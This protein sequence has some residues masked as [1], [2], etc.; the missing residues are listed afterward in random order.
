LK[1]GSNPIGLIYLGF[2]QQ[3]QFE[4]EQRNLVAAV[5]DIAGNALNRM[6]AT[7]ELEL[8]VNRRE[9][10]LES[11]YQVTSSASETL[12]MHQ[13]LQQA[14]V[15]TLEAVNTAS[16]A[17]Y[18]L[19][20]SEPV[21]HP[22]LIV[23]QGVGQDNPQMFLDPVFDKFLASVVR[24]K[25]AVVI[26][27]IESNLQPREMSDKILSFAGLPMRIK[28]R[29]IGILTIVREGGEQVILE[30]MTLLSFIA[31]HLA[32]VIENTRLYKRAEYN[33]VLDERSRLARDLHDSVTQSLFSAN[34]HIA[35][36]QKYAKL[37]NY[38][39]VDSTL[40]QIGKLTQQALNDLR[41][42]VYEL[43]ASEE[44]QQG[45]V[46]ALYNRLEAVENRAN[47]NVETD[48]T[49][50]SRLP[51]R[52]EE[53]LYRIAIEALNNSLKHARAS[54]VRVEFKRS[55]DH[56]LLAIQ[57][58]GVG[59]NGDKALLS[60]GYGMTT[61]HQR[62]DRIGGL[63]HLISNPGEGTRIEVKFPL[64]EYLEAKEGS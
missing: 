58:N 17:I 4:Q 10:E 44:I 12:D 25:K 19:D 11:I 62:T 7:E 45:L 13:A 43:R 32:L 16:G 51:E 2:E 56:L 64:L 9:R 29:V 28:D 55:G 59:F 34:L 23:Y 52:I 46:S 14:L 26:P 42:M 27:D 35:G 30:E 21:G 50:L 41:L 18:L 37:E 60:G 57:D 54:K 40:N 24:K 8:M 15:L 63:F 47:I 22:E 3:N 38:P 39:K 53:N 36:A 33:A 61:M 5:A 48:L 49:W 20:E 31:D 6:S 1:S